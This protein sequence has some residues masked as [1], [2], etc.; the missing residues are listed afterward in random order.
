MWKSSWN[1]WCQSKSI[2]N[3]C[4]IFQNWHFSWT[5]KGFSYVGVSRWLFTKINLYFNSISHDLCERFSNGSRHLEKKKLCMSDWT[6]TFLIIYISSQD[7]WLFAACSLEA[8]VCWLWHQDG[9]QCCESLT[10]NTSTWK[11]LW[12]V[13]TPVV[14]LQAKT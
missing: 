2:W 1:S 8:N 9:E 12:Q 6:D 4:I 14:D 11:R 13:R 3:L 7:N 10:L 5:S